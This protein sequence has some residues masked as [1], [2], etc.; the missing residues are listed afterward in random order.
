MIDVE[1]PEELKNA[2]SPR[3]A[4][5]YMMSA[6]GSLPGQP[7]SLENVAEIAKPYN[8]P[9]L[10]DAAAENLTIPNVHLQQGATIVAYSGGKAIR[11]R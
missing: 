4:M 1:T 3:T 10:M 7:L 2:I 8:I 5:I 9:I 11:L 6:K